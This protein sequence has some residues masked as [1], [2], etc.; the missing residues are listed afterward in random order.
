[1]TGMAD[2][3]VHKTQMNVRIPSELLATVRQHCR[4]LG[5]SIES[6]VTELIELDQN[7]SMPLLG[8]NTAT[9][10]QD[11]E[12]QLAGSDYKAKLEATGMPKPADMSPKAKI[13]AGE[14]KRNPR[15]TCHECGKRRV[16]QDD[17]CTQCA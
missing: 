7:G 4:G 2:P 3:P 14:S 15:R 13:A 6:Y 17:V 5:C 16:L 11:R 8:K 1:M 10:K 9:H 12:R